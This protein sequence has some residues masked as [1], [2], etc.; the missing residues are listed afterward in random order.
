[1]EPCI[2]LRYGEI[3]LKSSRTRGHFEQLYVK[4]IEDALR[5]QGV[6]QWKLKNYGGRFVLFANQI[7]ELKDVLRRVPG[8]QSFSPACFFSFS[9]K[10]DLLEKV[11]EYA[12]PRIIRKTFCVRVRRVGK[13][14]LFTSQDLEREAGEIL[15]E[16]SAGVQ[17]QQ[18]EII[19]SVEVRGQEAFLY[20]ET[21]QGLGGLPP[22]SSG[23]VLLLFSGGIDSPVAAYHLIKRGCQVDFLFINLLEEKALNDVARV[24]NYL[25]S[26][27]AFGYTPRCF[28]VPARRLVEKIRE[29]VPQRL[30]QLA[31]KTCFY[32]I[33]EQIAKKTGALAIATG[34]ALSQKSTQ[35]LESLQF[36]E[37]VKTLP[38]LRPLLSLDKIEITHL[39][40]K[41]GTLA[42]SEKVKEYCNLSEGPVVTKPNMALLQKIPDLTTEI[43]EA[44]TAQQPFTGFLP[45]AEEEPIAFSGEPGQELICVDVRPQHQQDVAPLP[46]TMSRPYPFVLEELDTFEKNKH[47]LFICDFGVQSEQ[48]AFL[49]R[50]KGMAAAGISVPHFL[51][52]FQ[53]QLHGSKQQEDK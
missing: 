35:T 3:G 24:Y 16:K 38:V 53:K 31:L 8:I 47:Y 19:I 11:Q 39:A 23:K 45:F 25:I 50:K 14:H 13:D 10:K 30:R 12:A 7:E 21:I 48:V 20:T 33:G 43:Q 9:D 4:A 22:T 34:E 29:V 1:M 36:L 32:K 26:Q 6:K 52:Y 37:Q 28:V 41:I 44:V 46:T 17:L 49:L 5:K 27:Y 42:A 40:Q 18:P 2:L 51:K 15:Y